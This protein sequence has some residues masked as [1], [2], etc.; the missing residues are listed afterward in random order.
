ML[1]FLIAVIPWIVLKITNG[2][3]GTKKCKITGKILRYVLVLIMLVVYFFNNFYQVANLDLK[4][5][6]HIAQSFQVA[7]LLFAFTV[8]IALPWWNFKKV[9]NGVYM[10]NNDN[11]GSN[12][13]LGSDEYQ[14]LTT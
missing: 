6:F 2:D 14:L 9:I 10:C 1:S 4:S 11:T 13:R 8:I 5:L 3:Q 12:V 7:A